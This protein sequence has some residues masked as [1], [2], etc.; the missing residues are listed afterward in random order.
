MNP[1]VDVDEVLHIVRQGLF[2]RIFSYGVATYGSGFRPTAGSS[3]RHYSRRS[4][5]AYIH[6]IKRYIFFHGKRH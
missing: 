4:E 1:A 5:K 6:W 2:R 3:T